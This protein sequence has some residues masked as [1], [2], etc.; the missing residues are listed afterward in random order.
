MKFSLPFSDIVLFRLVLNTRVNITPLL[1]LISLL[2]SGDL[3]FE[4]VRQDEEEAALFLE[5]VVV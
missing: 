5:G 4:G 3:R 2:D 1:V